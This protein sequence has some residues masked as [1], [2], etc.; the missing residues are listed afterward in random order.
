VLQRAAGQYSRAVFPVQ[1][2][3]GPPGSATYLAGTITVPIP[4]RQ[5][6]VLHEVAH[7]LTGT[8]YTHGDE[9]VAAYT[10][11]LTQEMGDT[12]AKKLID[13]L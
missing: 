1:Y 11:I 13:N 6:T 4:V 5:I 9:F 2:V 12:I 7:H 8:T 3:Q 10:Y